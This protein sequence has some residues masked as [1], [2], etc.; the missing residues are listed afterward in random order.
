MQLSTAKKNKDKAQ[1]AQEIQRLKP[2]WN[3]AKSYVEDFDELRDNKE[4]G[5]RLLEDEDL[6]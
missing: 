2:K 3:K 4:K 5:Q 6:N 1:I